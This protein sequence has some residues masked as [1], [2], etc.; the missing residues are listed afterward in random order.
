VLRV[1]LALALL[2]AVGA[3]WARLLA[4]GPVGQI[5]GGWLRGRHAT[6]LPAD[7][8]FANEEPYLLVESDAW[9]LPYSAQVWFLAHGGRLHLLLPSFFGDGLKRR[10]DDDPRVSVS[11]GGT[12]YE[13]VAVPVTDAAATGALLAPVIRRQFAIEISGEARPVGRAAELWV[14]RLDDPPGA[15]VTPDRTS[16]GAGEAPAG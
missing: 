8:S 10:L 6:V 5:P 1:L 4:N 15:K 9:T 12:L 3:A 16:S 13:Q 2:L 7:W 11:L 14:Y